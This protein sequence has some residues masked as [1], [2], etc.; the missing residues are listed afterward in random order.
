MVYSLVRREKS[1][2]E[3][4]AFKKMSVFFIY[5]YGTIQSAD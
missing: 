2:I 5:Q 1:N 3:I 4:R